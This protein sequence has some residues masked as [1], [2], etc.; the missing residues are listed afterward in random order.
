MVELSADEVQVWVKNMRYPAVTCPLC[1]VSAVGCQ[2]PA[3]RCQVNTCVSLL[4]LMLMLTG[5]LVWLLPADGRL[6]DRAE[7]CDE[8]PDQGSENHLPPGELPVQVGHVH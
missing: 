3:A 1:Q 5:V 7:M 8:R 2:M 6:S 4:L